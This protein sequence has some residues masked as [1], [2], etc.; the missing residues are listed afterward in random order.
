MAKTFAKDEKYFH[1]RINERRPAKFKCYPKL[2][3]IITILIVR[4]A[5]IEISLH[6]FTK[7]I[8]VDVK[9]NKAGEILEKL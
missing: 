3:V 9:F 8:E 1:E 5:R 2:I 4:K 7:E 6:F